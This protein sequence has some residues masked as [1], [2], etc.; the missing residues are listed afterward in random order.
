MRRPA[1]PAAE[2]GPRRP[3]LAVLPE[4]RHHLLERPSP[5][6]LRALFRT[7]LL[8][9]G[10]LVTVSVRRVVIGLSSVFPLQRLFVQALANLQRLYPLR[11]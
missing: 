11:G 2:E 6:T 4:V 10:A 1:V 7:R 3:D 9:L 5:A 8:N